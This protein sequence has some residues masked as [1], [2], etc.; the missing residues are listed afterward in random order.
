[1]LKSIITTREIDRWVQKWD[2]FYGF[3]LSLRSLDQISKGIRI[4]FIPPALLD[5]T[6]T[7]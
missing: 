5:A 4:F 3:S 7:I 2:I 6:D 1:M